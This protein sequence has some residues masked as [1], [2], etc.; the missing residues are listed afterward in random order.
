APDHSDAGNAR[1]AHVEEVADRERIRVAEHEHRAA[2]GNGIGPADDL[3]TVFR[4][5]RLERDRV[6]S[7]GAEGRRE[8]REPRAVLDLDVS[9]GYADHRAA[10]RGVRFE[11]LA[12]PADDVLLRAGVLR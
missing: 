1:V 10:D 6:D 2:G 11:E 4:S 9:A 5:M 3:V 7:T 8:H 12:Q